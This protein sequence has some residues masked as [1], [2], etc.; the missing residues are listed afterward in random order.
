MNYKVSHPTKKIF[1]E[2][3]PKIKK[4]F[5]SIIDKTLC[6]NKFKIQNLSDSQDT[7]SLKKIR[8]KQ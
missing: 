8:F 6:L 4:Y 1:C 5:K 3:D 2:I 7:T